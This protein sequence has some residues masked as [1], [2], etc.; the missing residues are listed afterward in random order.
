MAYIGKSE[1]M[2]SVLETLKA[3]RQAGV[4]CI[5]WGAPGTGKTALIYALAEELNIPVRILLGSTMDPTDLSGLP[6][7]KSVKRDTEDGVVE[8]NVTQTTVPDW[9]D[10][11][12]AAGTGIVFADELNN[13][14]PAVQSAL[15]TFIQDKKVGNRKLP[16]DV[17]ILAASNEPEDAADGYELA[18]PLAN[19]LL[20]IQWLP[21]KEDWF[22][23]M[24][25][26]WGDVN[27]GPELTD[28]RTKIV[29]FLKAYPNLLQAQPKADADAGKAW[30]SRR[31]WDNAAKALAAI[32][33]AGNGVRNQ[34]LTGLVG[35]EA[36]QQ[37]FKWEKALKLPA[38]ESVLA[39]PDGLDWNGMSADVALTLLN[40]TIGFFTKENATESGKVFIVAYKGGKRDIAASLVPNLIGRVKEVG[41]P[42][43][44]LGPIIAELAQVTNEAGI[45]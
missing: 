9:A 44:I 3:A 12:I 28:I 40:R 27:A 24:L 23:G 31:S 21:P 43:T 14:T 16:E 25:A 36:A 37:F 1:Y 19:R 6:S 30:P 26:N 29:V 8:Y 13:S 41:A 45:R 22:D 34:I 33:N 10:D 11:M 42:I 15:L 20:H 18:P 4:A 38:H 7:L 5:L 39:N 32:P 17:W 2:R 35:E